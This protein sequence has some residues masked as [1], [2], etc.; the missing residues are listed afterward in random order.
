MKSATL[1]DIAERAGVSPMTV[2]LAL[3]ASDDTPRRMRLA[4][5]ERI[6]QTARAMNYRANPA[7][8]ALRGGRAYNIGF[9]VN[10]A[11]FDWRQPFWSALVIAL[12]LGQ[13]DRRAGEPFDGQRAIGR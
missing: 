12:H 13:L 7:A 10:V 1:H 2:S 9:H 11:E 3:R 6:L 4:T 5:R 8:R